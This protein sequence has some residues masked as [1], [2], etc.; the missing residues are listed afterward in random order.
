MATS[1]SN[2]GSEPLETGI[3]PDN[4]LADK[5]NQER[6]VRRPSSG[7]ILPVNWFMFRAL[8]K[9]NLLID[10]YHLTNQIMSLKRSALKFQ[11]ILTGMWAVLSCLSLV[12]CYQWSC[13]QVNSWRKNHTICQLFPCLFFCSSPPNP[14]KKNVL[15]MVAVL[16]E[17]WAASDFQY[18]G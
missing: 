13:I 14:K 10:L 16:T 8:Y 11:W 12:G 18:L 3:C 17:W 2:P 5:S 9:S 4:W 15:C 7:G 1:L 6:F